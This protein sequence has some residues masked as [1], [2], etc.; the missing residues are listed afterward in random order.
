MKPIGI[1]CWLAQTMV[2]SNASQS[3][4]STDPKTLK[5][6]HELNEMGNGPIRKSAF[7]LPTVRAYSE[8]PR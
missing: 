3:K 6:K 7:A 8:L 4:Q 5:Q 2:L 1:P